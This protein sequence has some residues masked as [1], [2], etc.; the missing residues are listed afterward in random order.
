MT[1]GL[2]PLSQTAIRFFGNIGY[3]DYEG[4][5]VNLQ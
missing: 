3:H 5:A 4:P 1:C 2:L